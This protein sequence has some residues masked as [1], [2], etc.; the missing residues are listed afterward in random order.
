MDAIFI[1]GWHAGQCDAGGIDHFKSGMD[2]IVAPGKET[3][4]FIRFTAFPVLLLRDAHF[5]FL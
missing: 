1:L 4:F 2:G 5:P 3:K